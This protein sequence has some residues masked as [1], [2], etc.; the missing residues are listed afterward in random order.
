MS[1][2]NK[3]QAARAN[4]S[5]NL[6]RKG[7]FFFQLVHLRAICGQLVQTK[8]TG[9]CREP[10][11]LQRGPDWRSTGPL[12]T[13]ALR[14]RRAASSV[15][16]RWGMVVFVRTTI[17]LKLT[18]TVQRGP[19]HR[20]ARNGHGESRQTPVQPSRTTISSKAVTAGRSGNMCATSQRRAPR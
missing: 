12:T 16:H 7:Q 18:R 17:C 5:T 13:R 19:L 11:V 10:A 6:L 2:P 15:I 4:L 3:T 8:I 20:H 9:Q 1:K 14:K